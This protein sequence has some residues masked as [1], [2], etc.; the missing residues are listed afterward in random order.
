MRGKPID[1]A[2]LNNPDEP[3]GDDGDEHGGAGGEG[4]TGTEDRGDSLPV[5]S[6]VG[7]GDEQH[8]GPV[9]ARIREHEV[10]GNRDPGEEETVSFRPQPGQ[11]ERNRREREE[12]GRP[13]KGL[14]HHGRFGGVTEA[15]H[16][17][18]L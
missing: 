6:S 4:K 8:R 16:E 5:S 11:V 18:R 3:A 9:D 12:Q 17:S 7:L 10:A 14:R 2:P 1:P 15:A 13:V